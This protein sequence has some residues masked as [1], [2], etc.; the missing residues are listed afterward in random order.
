M[1]TR[2]DL[3]SLA[4]EKFAVGQP[5]R[6]SEDQ[7]LVRGQGQYTDDVNIDSQVHAA[8]VRSQVAH[9]RIKAIDTSV[10][11]A[12]PG[13]LAVY[14][15]ADLAK[16]GYGNMVCRLPL[17]SQDGSAL[18]A[19]ERPAL[20]GDTVRFVGDPVVCVIAETRDQ[21]LDAA[22]AV[23]LDIDPLPAVVDC[24]AAIE[25]GAPQVYS[26]VPGNVALDYLY[27]DRDKVAEAFAKAAHVTKMRL[28]QMRLVVN[29][30]EPRA[31]VAD[32]DKAEGKFTLYAQTQ[33]VMSSRATAAGMMKVPLDKMRF[34][35][36][37]VGGS[38]GMK[39]AIF[40]EYVCA[41]HG[42][43]ELGRPVKWTDT[44]SDGYLSDHHGRA[45]DFDA[46]L[47]LDKD[48][49][50]LAMRF[51]GYGDM[52]AYLTAMGPLFSSFNV[53]K[54]TASLYRTPVMTVRTRCVFTNTVPI[55][56]Y[57]G[58]GRPEGNYYMERLIETAAHE[59]GIDPIEMRRRNHVKP[60]E[61]PYKAASGSVYD[62]G[63]FPA[64]LTKAVEASDWNGFAARAKE[65]EARGLL[66]GRGVGQ[67]LEVTAPVQKEL[68][69]IRF[70]TDGSVTVLTGTHDHGQ[71]HQTSFAQVVCERLGVPFDRIRVLQTDS[72]VLAAGSGTGGSK[73][74]M[75]SGTALVEASAR[76]IDKAKQAAAHLLEASPADVEFSG[77]RLS[78]VG[79]DRGMT[80]LEVAHRIAGAERLPEE[81]PKSLDVEYVHESAPATYPNGCHVAEVEI[82][83]A[84]GFISVV[85]YTMVGDF[86]TLLNPMIVEG[87]LRGGAVQG[88]GQCLMERA[89][90]TDDGQLVT[91]SHMDYALPRAGDAPSMTFESLAVPT[92]SNPLGVKGCG[93]AGVAG[94]LTSIM[95]AV[96]DAMRP[97]GVRHIEMPATPE[98]VWR[99]LK[100]GKTG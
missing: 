59:M 67:F 66:R 84:T 51:D 61:M 37:N 93:E 17:K 28:Q 35:A 16:A 88:L 74:A 76:V 53:V 38:F 79:T 83:P 64:I 69:A 10:A 50:I 94:A 41:L 49:H 85:R 11:R 19:P 95:N 26:D 57:R 54:H 72:D 24:R 5:V 36:V 81:C 15:A 75:A 96:M 77:G 73:S 4:I 40:P 70:E 65:S 82:D 29:A 43:R 3:D 6:R 58:A 86:G 87:Q 42:A 45:Q 33:G 39:G 7:K 55:T 25:D 27:G 98:V 31:A 68:G 23:A 20:A 2:Q 18:R 71:G 78:I 62:C 32:Y 90:Y 12:M 91:G 97:Y 1:S 8:F 48:G 100:A 46:E 13:V 80:V 14:T 44:R 63:D 22:E 9:G 47:A 34:V 21:A 89:V 92:K 52:G 56:A 99:A 30:M 60:E